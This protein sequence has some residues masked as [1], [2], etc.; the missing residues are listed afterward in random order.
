MKRERGYYCVGSRITGEVDIV[1]VTADTPKWRRKQARDTREQAI[2]AYL[3]ELNILA[4]NAARLLQHER[5]TG[6]VRNCTTCQNGLR[7]GDGTTPDEYCHLAMPFRDVFGSVTMMR[8]R[9]GDV[10]MLEMLRHYQEG[11]PSFEPIGA[12]P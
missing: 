8:C 7:Y 9:Q 10:C 5:A 12:K 1:P 11:C 2:C 3:E 4:R 6:E